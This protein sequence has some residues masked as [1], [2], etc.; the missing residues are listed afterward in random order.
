MRIAAVLTFALALC[1][2]GFGQATPPH[3]AVPVA[4]D[5][6]PEDVKSVEAL[7]AALYDVISGPAGERDWARFRTLCIPEVRLIMNTANSQGEI[8][9]RVMSAE[10][11]QQVASQVFNQESFYERGVHND[12]DQFGTIAQVFS[13]YESSHEKNGKPFER[14][15]NSMQFVYDGHRWWTVTILWDKESPTNPIPKKYLKR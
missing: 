9:R 1:S 8:V 2:Y 4:S 5:A 12:V 14:G 7:V 3:I 10:D 11:F 6:R 13:T 15:I